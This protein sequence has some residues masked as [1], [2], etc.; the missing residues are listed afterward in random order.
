MMYTLSLIVVL[1]DLQYKLYLTTC[2]IFR[3]PIRFPQPPPR[4]GLFLKP[5]IILFR[6]KLGIYHQ[7][8]LIIDLNGVKE[9]P[10]ASNVP[11]LQFMEKSE[12]VAS[13][14]YP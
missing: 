13:D 7:F 2:S 3:V 5:T 14:K 10:N 1:E 9:P 12:H 11:P 8:C 4:G 6:D